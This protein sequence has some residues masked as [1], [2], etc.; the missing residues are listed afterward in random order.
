MNNISEPP[1]PKEN[2]QLFEFCGNLADNIIDKFKQDKYQIL[3]FDETLYKLILDNKQWLKGDRKEI[4]RLQFKMK[5]YYDEYNDGNRENLLF[6]TNHTEREWI[7][8][9]RIITEF[10]EQYRMKF[11]GKCL[12]I[13]KEG[14][15]GCMILKKDMKVI[16]YGVIEMKG[17]D[18]LIYITPK[19]MTQ[20]RFTSQVERQKR[21]RFIKKYKDGNGWN[22]PLLIQKGYAECI[23]VRDIYR[24]LF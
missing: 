13:L 17:H 24:V 11:K 5:D 18:I 20:L 2:L 12:D 1:V 14:H 19:G 10:N 3:E 21:A 23:L 9:E 6:L 4:H 22:I 7:N 8:S 16:N 15:A